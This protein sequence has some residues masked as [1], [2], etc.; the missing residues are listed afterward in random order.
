MSCENCGTDLRFDGHIHCAECA[1]SVDLCFVCFADRAAPRSHNPAH[2]YF[3]LPELGKDDTSWTQNERL[4]LVEATTKV[5][6]GS[7][8]AT[9]KLVKTKSAGD[10]EEEFVKLYKKWQSN[11]QSSTAFPDTPELSE[12]LTPTAP[13]PPDLPGLLAVRGDFEMEYDEGAELTV[14][15]LEFSTDDLP[16]E[17]SL[18]IE[19]LRAYNQR[20]AFRAEVKRFVLERGLCGGSEIRNIGELEMHARLGPIQRFF[21]NKKKFDEFVNLLLAERR[22][23]ER[24]AEIDGNTEMKDEDESKVED[25]DEAE[26]SIDELKKDEP[27]ATGSRTRNRAPARRGKQISATK[28]ILESAKKVAQTLQR[29]DVKERLVNNL[30]DEAKA[31]AS[32]LGIKSELLNLIKEPI[33]VSKYGK[34]FEFII[35]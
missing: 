31:A 12:L 20:V 8:E 7:W 19:V 27:K 29:D 3:V 22:I 28:A 33:L 25:E 34:A 13:Q 5:G 35:E 9:A 16:A 11:I 4:R 14:A 17:R 1:D 21:D 23:C 30:T 10:C 26:E 18:K 24:L 2:D 6:V 32:K 15:D